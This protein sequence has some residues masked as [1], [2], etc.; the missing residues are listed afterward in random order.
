MCQL[1]GISSNSSTTP[2]FSSS[3]LSPF[4]QRGGNTDCHEHGWGVAYFYHNF[5]DSNSNSESDRDN[6]NNKEGEK[7]EKK[8]LCLKTIKGA[9]PAATSDKI[10]NL[11]QPLT[12]QPDH[13][14]HNFNYKYH[15][16]KSEKKILESQ[17]LLAHIRYATAGEVAIQNVHP[18]HRELFGVEFVFAHNGDVPMFKKGGGRGRGVGKYEYHEDKY[19]EDKENTRIV[20][21][22]EGDT[23]SEQIFCY[24]LN[25]LHAKFDSFPPLDDLYCTVHQLCLEISRNGNDENDENE[26][27]V[28]LNFLLG[29]GE[30]MFAYSWPGSRPGSKTWNGLYYMLRDDN[31]DNCEHGNGGMCSGGEGAINDMNDCCESGLESGSESSHYRRQSQLLLSPPSH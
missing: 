19:Y 8:K 2:S 23:D 20:F 18:F 9:Q 17:N 6:M 11:I 31:G 4:I 29:F 14:H 21:E 5:C 22:A 13:D 10:Q 30:Y 25:A 7:K 28:I 24:I 15:R 1:L 26:Q 12:N 27:G 3:L 16:S